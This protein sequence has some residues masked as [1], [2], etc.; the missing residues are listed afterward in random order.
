MMNMKYQIDKGSSTMNQTGDY[1]VY[2]IKYAHLGERLSS[3]N[4]IFPDP[5]EG[6]MPLDY[7]VWAIVGKGRTFLVDL[8]F[9]AEDA[10]A[11]GRT[12]LRT[13]GEGLAM[14][15][16]APADVQDVIVTHMHY[17]HIGSHHEFP[18]ARLHLQDREMAYAT[19]RDM[20]LEAIRHAFSIESVVG[21]VRAVHDGRVE[22]HDGDTELV[23]GISL[24][25]IGGHTKG[26]QV[27]RVATRRGNVIL[28]SDAAHFYANMETAN[29]FPVVYNVADMLQG[30]KRLYQLA[31]T[32]AHVVPGHD[33]LVLARYPAA[34]STL[35]GIVHRLD[36][37]PSDG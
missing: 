16:I 1:E 21:L 28:A 23:P 13:P 9:S 20:S 15:G 34:S 36:T 27:V 25:L 31:D 30:H 22:F 12:L 26:L 14:I 5:H 2:A 24:H 8:G 37:A 6:P 33:P 32:Q 17:D 3:D 18:N 7:F 29:P 10:K 11:R 19:G 4:F 35:D